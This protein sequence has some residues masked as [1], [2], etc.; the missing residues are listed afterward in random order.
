MLWQLAPNRDAPMRQLI[1]WYVAPIVFLSLGAVW[2]FGVFFDKVAWALACTALLPT[3]LLALNFRH[4]KLLTGMVS[5]V[6]L[7]F[8]LFS[9]YFA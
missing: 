3:Q 4:G 5:T 7:F 8:V 1:V 9:P 2:F 6:V